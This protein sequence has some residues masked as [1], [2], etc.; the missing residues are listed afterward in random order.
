[1][2]K[3][4]LSVLITVVTILLL[5]PVLPARAQTAG[6]KTEAD[7][8]RAYLQLLKDN[9]ASIEFYNWQRRLFSPYI[10]EDVSRNVVLCDIYGDDTPELLYITACELYAYC[11]GS[12]L[13]ITTFENGQIKV[14]YS[15]EFDTDQWRLDYYF[16]KINGSKSLYSYSLFADEFFSESYNE[17][18]PNA[19]GTLS[20]DV[21]CSCSYEEYDRCSGPNG[22]EITKE[23][24]DELSNELLCS[25]SET[26][27]YGNYINDIPDIITE[28]GC[29]AM[30]CDEAIGFLERKLLEA[31]TPSSDI[32]PLVIKSDPNDNR[33]F[34]FNENEKVE[35]LV[36]STKA[37]EYNPRL[38]HFLACMARAAYS[39]DQLRANY[40]QLGFSEPKFR[41]YEQEWG[42]F[43]L[44]NKN[45]T[46]R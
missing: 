11:C 45:W 15:G 13:N 34:I 26:L 21:Y 14:L 1:M 41:H 35:D 12:T 28:Y 7:A 22:E 29:P 10:H 36:L 46:Q 3:R 19:D 6:S 42:D 16:F 5:I 2:A 23:R 20:S 33:D 18:R 31:S 27:M 30:T 17:F 4:V 25:V 40:I 37:S 39:P 8:Y 9:Q 38:A 44:V 32:S 24:Y 43:A